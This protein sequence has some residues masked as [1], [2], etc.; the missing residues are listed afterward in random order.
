M[1]TETTT[2]QKKQRRKTPAERAALLDEFQRSGLTRPEFSNTHNIALSTLSK[3]LTNAKRKRKTSAPVLFR[4][5]SVPHIPTI[6]AIPWA[7][8]IV[9]PGGVL[10]RLREA[11]SLEDLS[12]LLRGR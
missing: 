6:A 8:E 12:W 3:W 11:L 5:L 4:E 1:G 9:G 2:D 10:I 7:A